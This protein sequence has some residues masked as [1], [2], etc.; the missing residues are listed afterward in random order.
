VTVDTATWNGHNFNGKLGLLAHEITHS[1]Q[2]DKIGYV[3]FGERYTP[4]FNGNHANYF[5]SQSLANTP[6]GKVDVV[7]NYYTLDQIAERFKYEVNPS[8]VRVR[9]DP[10][11]SPRICCQPW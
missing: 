6:I 9:P 3:E 1:V 10:P 11:L 8:S 2:Y 4:E 5:L 7:S